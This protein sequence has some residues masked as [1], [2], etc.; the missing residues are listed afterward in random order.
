MFALP[1]FETCPSTCVPLG[2]AKHP[3]PVFSCLTGTLQCKSYHHPTC[4][5]PFQSFYCWSSPH[6]RSSDLPSDRTLLPYILP[7]TQS[8]SY[9]PPSD[10]MYFP[11]PFR[12]PSLN[13]PWYD[14]LLTNFSLPSPVRVPL[15]NLPSIMD[16]VF[17]IIVLSCACEVVGK[18]RCLALQWL[19]CLLLCSL[20]LFEAFLHCFILL[21][22]TWS[23]CTTA[24]WNFP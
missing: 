6:R 17:C 9:E 11:F 2:H 14:S 22:H 7:F 12:T 4:R 23:T 19:T 5:T 1:F 8:P 20:E 10:Q 15:V 24:W 13:Y 3:I 16:L 18:G 21:Y